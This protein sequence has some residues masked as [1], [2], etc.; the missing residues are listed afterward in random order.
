MTRI[1]AIEGIDGTGKGT[2]AAALAQRLTARGATVVSISFPVYDS[3]F[4]GQVGRL[5]AGKDGVRADAVDGKSMALWFA[6]DRWEAFNKLDYAG[7]DYLIINRYVLS[8]AVYQSIR[9]CDLGKPDLLDFVLA[10]EHGHLGLPRA[11]AHI[12]LDMDAGDAAQ[13]VDK[14]GFRGYV[15]SQRDVYEA[16]PDIQQRAREKYLAYARRMP[17]IRIVPC[18]TADGGLKSIGEIGR[19]IDG[20]LFDIFQ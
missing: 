10:L 5:L 15:G 19:L 13:N 17:E 3:F 8:N 1:V 4:G 20:A 12:V 9:D 6:L 14:K 7:A 16:L 11:H 18:M 2:Q